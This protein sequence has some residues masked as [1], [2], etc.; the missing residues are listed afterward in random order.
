MELIRYVLKG[1][2]SSKT[3]DET[4]NRMFDGPAAALVFLLKNERLDTMKAKVQSAAW[5]AMRKV[6]RIT[7]EKSLRNIFSDVYEAAEEEVLDSS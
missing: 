7:F 6:L 4:E 2:D 1:T 5:V 3:V